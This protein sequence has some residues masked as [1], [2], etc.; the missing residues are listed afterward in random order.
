MGGV[1]EVVFLLSPA[2]EEAPEA[3]SGRAAFTP[4][5][6]DA[7]VDKLADV[8]RAFETDTD[9]DTADPVFDIL[10][11]LSAL[12]S[13][14]IP[15]VFRVGGLRVK[16]EAEAMRDF[17]IA[18]CACAGSFCAVTG[19]EMARLEAWVKRSDGGESAVAGGFIR[20]VP[21][22]RVVLVVPSALFFRTPPP[23]PL[24]SLP[25]GGATMDIFV[26]TLLPGLKGN[27]ARGKAA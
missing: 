15:V 7:V 16:R 1:L 26:A 24:V 11:K 12:F 8:L 21:D 3:E 19:T 4:P 13:V 10:V 9:D 18:A 17:D 2:L 6:F 22:E 14:G 5:P 25:N 20:G 23:I 27:A